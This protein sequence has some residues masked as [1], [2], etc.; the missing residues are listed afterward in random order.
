VY[1]LN[2]SK[3]ITNLREYSEYIELFQRLKIDM[4]CQPDSDQDLKLFK[5]KS[6]IDEMV[7]QLK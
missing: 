1:N 4:G 6:E 2:L 3:P 5:K 7:Y